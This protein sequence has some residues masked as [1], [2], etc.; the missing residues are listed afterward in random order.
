MIVS[1][2]LLA[3]LFLQNP[4]A[5]QNPPA[6]GDPHQHG[7]PPA[8]PPPAPDQPPM[9]PPTPPP[10]Y[11]VGELKVDCVAMLEGRYRFS[12][13]APGA[14]R[15]SE[16]RMQFRL[17][18]EKITQIQRHGQLILSEVV[19][20]TGRSLFDPSTYSAEDRENTRLVA[21]PAEKL[22]ETGLL[23]VTRASAST[24]G[25]V[26]LKRIRGS[27]RL[28]LSKEYVEVTVSNP[29]QFVGKSID[30]PRLK[31]LGINVR[32]V[33]PEEFEK[34]Y[35]AG[36]AIALRYET[37]AELVRSAALFDGWMKPIRVREAAG[38]TKDGKSCTVFTVLG[39]DLNADAQLVVQVFPA[40]E[41][42]N[43]PVSLDD[44]P[45]P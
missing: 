9:S 29:T 7:A 19:D 22:K 41:D 11:A 1:L 30:D 23:L 34:P 13:P 12:D 45:L 27:V 38:T 24:R 17:V 28:I 2:G 43:V 35:E 32:L 39:G 37:K 18:G 16:L 42:V 36:K 26:T 31:D 20:D 15:E 14:P 21:G 6:G 5:P 44:V 3:A 4:A 33:A 10:N 25:A 8:T 40:V